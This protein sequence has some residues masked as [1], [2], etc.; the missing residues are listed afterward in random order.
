M[1]TTDSLDLSREVDK[2]FELSF[3]YK[4]WGNNTELSSIRETQPTYA[5]IWGSKSCD[6]FF[7]FFLWLFYKRSGSWN[8]HGW[9]LLTK[10]FLFKSSHWQQPWV[11]LG[12]STK[13]CCRM[14]ANANRQNNQELLDLQVPVDLRSVLPFIIVEKEA[15]NY[16]ISKR[17]I[18]YIIWEKEV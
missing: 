10:C 7:F 16:K 11:L 14:I 8:F 6:F 2:C 15:L 5:A 18:T 3:R 1:R 13:I 9:E 12:V 4:S 17:Q